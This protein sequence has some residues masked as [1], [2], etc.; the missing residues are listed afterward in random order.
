MELGG[1]GLAAKRN[2]D[3]TCCSGW[4]FIWKDAQWPVDQPE[5]LSSSKQQSQKKNIF[6]IYWLNFEVLFASYCFIELVVG[7]LGATGM[8]YILVGGC[9]SSNKSCAFLHCFS[10]EKCCAVGSHG[11]KSSEKKPRSCWPRAMMYSG[12]LPGLRGT[13][14]S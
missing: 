2:P 7:L 8:K 4:D 5:E 3:Y 6:R 12:S 13:A 11:S 1:L 9:R 10:Q 14:S